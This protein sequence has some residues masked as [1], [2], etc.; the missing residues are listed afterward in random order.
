MPSQH[1]KLIKALHA[2]LLH[3]RV[4]IALNTTICDSACGALA[5]RL[6]SGML[7]RVIGQVILDSRAEG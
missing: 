5:L 1:V 2:R 6:A 3:A 7:A 4:K